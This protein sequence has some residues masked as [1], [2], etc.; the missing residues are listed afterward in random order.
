MIKREPMASKTPKPALAKRSTSGPAG[1]FDL[2]R[3]IRGQKVLLDRDLAQ[4][5][6]VTTGNLN[7]AVT[8]NIER[9]PSDFMFQL[10]ADEAERSRFQIGILKRGQN[11]NYLPRAFTE[12]GVAMLSASA[13]EGCPS[14]FAL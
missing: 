7:K 8:R 10:T 5:Y 3:I 4:L 13:D 9:F 1:I 2:I 12:Q 14:P 11:I 6:G